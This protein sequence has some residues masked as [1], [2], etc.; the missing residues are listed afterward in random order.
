[1]I[2]PITI[3]IASAIFAGGAAWGGAKAALNGTKNRV[4]K[5]ETDF[6]IHM[7]DDHVVQSQ[8]LDRLARVETKIDLLLTR[9]EIP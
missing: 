5:M 1:M 8:M 3:T 7:R 4:K 9:K 2:D 6:V